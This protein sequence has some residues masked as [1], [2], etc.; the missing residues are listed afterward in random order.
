MTIKEDISG[1][2]HLQTV[3]TRLQ[4]VEEMMETLRMDIRGVKTPL[5]QLETRRDE[6]ISR[7]SEL[8]REMLRLEQSINED[9][10]KIQKSRDKLPLITTQKE[11]FALQK[12]IETMQKEKSRMEQDL[13]TRMGTLEEL[14]KERDEVSSQCQVE[15]AAFLKKKQEMENANTHFDAENNELKLKREDISREIS[16]KQLNHYNRILA[17]K[18]PPALVPIIERTCQGCHVTLPP[19]V[20]NDVRKANSIITCSYCGRILYSQT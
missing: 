1:L 15:E 17:H 10:D 6:L 7:I 4:E 9:D 14:Q 19:Q 16:P 3:D 20:Y 8:R 12:E 2:I 18:G 13:L 11:Y 5:T